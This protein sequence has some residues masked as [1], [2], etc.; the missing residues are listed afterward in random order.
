MPLEPVSI[1]AL[2][3]RTLTHTELQFAGYFAQGLTAE[4][5]GRAVGMPPAQARTLARDDAVVQA[6]TDAK[7]AQRRLLGRAVTRENLTMMLLQSHAKAA[8]VSEEIS[9]IKEIG[10]LNGLYAQGDGPTINLNIATAAQLRTMTDAELDALIANPAAHTA[11]I[12]ES[13]P[14]PEPEELEAGDGE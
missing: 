1:T 10:K 9:A 2:P 4:A 8:S 6:I 12:A 7:L 14:T 5:A 13:L 3:T 11:R